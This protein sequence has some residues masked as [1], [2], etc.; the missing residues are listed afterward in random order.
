MTLNLDSRSQ[1]LADSPLRFHHQLLPKVPC[2]AN[3]PVRKSKFVWYT[4]TD[5]RSRS[6]TNVPSTS[7]KCSRSFAA[8]A[9]QPTLSSSW[10]GCSAGPAQSPVS[11]PQLG[12]S[13][14]A[15]PMTM[16]PSGCRVAY[17]SSGPAPTASDPGH[18]QHFSTGALSSTL[19]RTGYRT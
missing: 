19:L 4:E 17:I 13:R 16:R 1:P 14:R 2:S 5:G 9:S 10:P 18:S 8:E 6:L 3:A 12:S 15:P 7:A 11:Q